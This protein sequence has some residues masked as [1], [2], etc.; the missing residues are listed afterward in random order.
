LEKHSVKIPEYFVKSVST[1]RL[2]FFSTPK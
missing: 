2:F 1:Q